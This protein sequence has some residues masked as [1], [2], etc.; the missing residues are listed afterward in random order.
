MLLCRLT[1]PL[2]KK[3][4]ATWNHV[5]L[6]IIL[7]TL[8]NKGRPREELVSKTSQLNKSPAN[9]VT[10]LWLYIGLWVLINALLELAKFYLN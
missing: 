10:D 4:K 8:I 6:L 7:F 3:P 9:S 1:E 5:V 2:N